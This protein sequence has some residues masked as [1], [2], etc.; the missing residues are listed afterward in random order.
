MSQI[1]SLVAPFDGEIILN[2]FEKEK[3]GFFF[4]T[5]D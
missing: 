3:V 5:N 4:I 1:P 2:V